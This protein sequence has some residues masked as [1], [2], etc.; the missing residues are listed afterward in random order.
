MEKKYNLNVNLN[1]KQK[2]SLMDFIK[3]GFFALVLA[4]GLYYLSQKFSSSNFNTTNIEVINYNEKYKEYEKIFEGMKTPTSNIVSNEQTVYF[5]KF[6]GSL[7]AV[8]V[9]YLRKE[10]EAILTVSKENEEV[11]INI[12][13][14]GG[15]VTGYG[16]V[17]SQ[18]Q[19][20]KNAGLKVTAVIDQVAASGGYMAA[21]V[22]DKVYAAPFAIVGSIGV[23][24]QVPIF[25]KLLDNL[26]VE[27]K[28]YTAGESK[29]TVTNFKT[30]TEEDEERFKLQLEIIHEQF[31]SHVK[32]Y[33]S[34]VDIDKIATGEFFL[35][36][37]ALSLNL[38]DGLNTT[39]DYLREKYLE[40]YNILQLKYNPPKNN[41]EAVAQTLARTF[42]IVYNKLLIKENELYFK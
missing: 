17:A 18:I 2:P 16:L 25:E 1:E 10:I 34:S 5:L 13:S 19:R 29:R 38:I 14:P 12:E 28:V 3:V 4:I 33:R 35:A 9:D 7:N 37:H 36:E 8:E 22:A 32:K 39:D 42:E 30:P 27:Y 41:K 31:K 24:S 6:T 40:G 26:G 11:I 21:V 15:S 20:L 23:V